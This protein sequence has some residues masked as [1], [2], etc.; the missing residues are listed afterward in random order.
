LTFIRKPDAAA[1]AA[2]GSQTGHS[3]ATTSEHKALVSLL[4]MALG[5]SELVDAIIAQSLIAAG[6]E[7]LPVSAP[8]LVAFVRAHLLT[9][10]SDHIGPRLT[11]ALVDDLVALIDPTGSLP[12]DP[13]IP[14]SSM[15]RPVARRKPPGAPRAPS[16]KLGVLLVDGDRV[17]RATVARAMLRSQWEVTVV[18]SPAELDEVLESG[19]PVDVAL[20]DATHPHAQALVETLARLRPHVAVVARSGDAIRTRALFAR[21]GITRSDIRSREAPAEELVDAVRRVTSV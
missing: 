16:A 10:L 2:G 8:D 19:D 21:L 4:E 12:T 13:S 6:R 9:S 15:P 14:P 11:I 5:T 7:E 18:D 3:Y 20:V 1:Q 17:G